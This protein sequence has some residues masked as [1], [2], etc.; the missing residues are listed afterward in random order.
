MLSKL[1]LSNLSKLKSHSRL[2]AII[3]NAGWLFADRILRMGASLVVGVWI[4]RYLGV[5]QYGLFNYAL[6]FVTLFTP[7]LTLGLDEI[8]VRHVVRESSNK[9]EI[10]GTTFWLKLLGG[11]ASVLLAVGITIFLGEREFLKI[12]LVAILAIAGIFRAAD[13]I[14]LWFQSQVQSKYAVI[15]KNIAFLLNTLIKV[16]LILTKAPL[17]AFAWVTLAEFAMNAVGLAIVYQYKGFSFL[18]W[19]WNF[20]V[21]KTLLKESLPLIFSGFAIMIFM[22]IDQIMLGQMIGDK[23]VGIYSAAVRLSEIW[24]FIPGAIVP[25]VAPSIYAAKDQ[26]DKVY[27]QRLG[28]LFRLLT[29]IAVAIAVPMTFLSDK[30]VM[31]LFG[32]GYAG[33]GAILAVHIWTSIF[34]FLG[35]ASSPWF[36]AEGLN[37]VTLG[38]TVFGAILNIILNFLLIPQYSGLGAAIATII[39]QAAAAFLCNA[40]DRRTQKIFKIQ[41]QSL[42]LFYK[43]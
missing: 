2:R 24:Y 23:E 28:Q 43:Y 16:A 32:N 20:Q 22:K 8:V 21:A 3:A 9:E 34:V 14:E 4:A 1:R 40:F 41:L 13:T 10:L 36:I 11:I 37:H 33:A 39:S 30:I 7:V 5:Q 19:R 26:S 6:A 31:V 18:S 17:L 38:K 29:C 35:F 12:S 42:L 25:S 27:Y 15:A